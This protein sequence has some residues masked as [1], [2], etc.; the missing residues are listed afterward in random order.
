MLSQTS[1][2]N[3]TSQLYLRSKT[4]QPATFSHLASAFFGN[5]NFNDSKGL[6]QES[7][8][9]CLFLIELKALGFSPL[10]FVTRFLL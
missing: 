7:F 4:L 2:H 3:S 10:Y 8:T 1:L 5:I 6:S 9:L